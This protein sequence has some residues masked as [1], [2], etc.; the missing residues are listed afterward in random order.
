MPEG[1]TVYLLARTLDR[2]LA[3]HVLAA[4]DFRVPQL[5]TRDLTGREVLGH[6]THGK[7]LLTRFSG[8]VTLHSHLLMDGEWSLTG[9]GKRLPA[10]LQDDVRVALTTESGTT[11][12]GRRVHRLELVPTSEESRVVG[13]L[14]PDPLREDWDA[15]EAVRR[16]AADPGWPL[17]S[18]LLDQTRMAGLG[19]LWANEIAFLTGV[20]PWT[21]VG[22]VDVERLVARSARALRHSALVPGA[23]QVTTGRSRPGEDHWVYGARRRRCLRCGTPIRRAEEIPNDPANRLTQWCPHCQPGPGPEARLTGRSLGT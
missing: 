8:D 22:E 1:D 11:A 7:H 20:S 10:R 4:S 3:G 9:P 12:W 15:D 2:A 6:D 23:Y 17:V 5:A 16:L 21:P 19:N 18:A 13:H 14:G